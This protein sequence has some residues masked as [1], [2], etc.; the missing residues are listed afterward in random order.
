MR[1]QIHLSLALALIAILPANADAEEMSAAAID[2]CVGSRDGKEVDFTARIASVYE[3]AG[4]A[5]WYGI[6]E[7]LC[8]L[9]YNIV[10]DA[11]A[12]HCVEGSQARIRGRI[13]AEVN[14]SNGFASSDWA[15]TEPHISCE[16]TK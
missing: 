12:S 11:P 14:H 16:E 2:A 5:A 9:N 13:F 10:L 7:R 15:L 3:E 1:K 6:D 4:G 8:D